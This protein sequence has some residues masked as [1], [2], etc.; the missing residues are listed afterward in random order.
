MAAVTTVVAL[1]PS[2]VYAKG[3]DGIWFTTREEIAHPWL[4]VHAGSG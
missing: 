4:A 3:F 2:S 1:S